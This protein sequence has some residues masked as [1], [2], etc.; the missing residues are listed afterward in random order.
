MQDQIDAD[1]V[2]IKV[3][4]PTAEAGAGSSAGFDG[5]YNVDN[6][7]AELAIAIEELKAMG[8]EISKENPIYIDLPMYSGSETYKNRANAFKQSV[9]KSLDGVIIIN[10]LDCPTAADWYNAAYYPDLG[11]QMNYDISDVSG[12]GPDWGDPNSYLD[13]MLPDYMGS[14]SKNLGIF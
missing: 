14:M 12:W 3:W 2:K 5:W 10:L 8:L 11:S 13:T 6:A 7:K 4:D 9:E 1:G